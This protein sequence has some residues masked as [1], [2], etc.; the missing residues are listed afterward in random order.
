[1]SSADSAR[2]PIEII[3]EEIHAR[4]PIMPE[5]NTMTPVFVDPLNSD[6]FILLNIDN[7]ERWARAIVSSQI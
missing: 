3:M 2:S 1:M 4:F 5:Y 6:H 7:V